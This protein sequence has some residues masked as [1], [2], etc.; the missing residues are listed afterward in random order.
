MTTAVIDRLSQRDF[1]KL[2]RFIHGHCGIKMP[3]AKKTMVEGRLRRRLRATGASTL[4]DYCRYLFEE[5][6]LE[7]E[8]V[9]LIDAVTTNKTDF[10]REPEHFRFLVDHAVPTLIG[11]RRFADGTPIKIWSAAASIGAEAY[12][13]AMVMAE[14]KRIHPTL[15]STIVGTD[16]C[17]EA[18]N[19]AIRGIYP[20]AMIAPIPLEYRQRYLLRAKSGARD[21]V[22]IIP[23]I[24]QSVVFGHLNLMETPYNIALDMHVIFCRN[25]LIY[26]DKQTQRNVLAQICH[27]LRPGGFLFLGHSETLTGLGLPLQPIAATIFR[28]T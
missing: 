1:D 20:E 17:T 11:T 27:H 8:K 26:F 25:I 13:I 21:R 23:E 9:G 12:T 22:R 7:E 4:S 3:P 18:L 16:I 24:R 28:R 6:G 14:L 10:F 19:T 2:A 15:R 5:G